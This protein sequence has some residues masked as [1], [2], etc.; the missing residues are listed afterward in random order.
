M[1]V[2]ARRDRQ[3]AERLASEIAALGWANRERFYPRLTSL[4]EAVEKALTVGRNT[5]LLALAFA[6][7]ADNPGGG[8]RGNT[9]W[10]IEA[11]HLA[12]VQGAVAGLIHDPALAAEAHAAGVGG[13]FT[14]RF[15]RDGGDRFSRPF[16][17]PAMVRALHDGRLVGRR[18]IFAGNAIDLGPMA[19]LDLG[20]MIVV[21]ASARVQCAD[22]A[23]LEALGIDIGQARCVVVKSRGHFRGGFDEFFDHARI[24]EVDAPGLT[25]PVLARFDWQHLPRPVLPLDP[26]TSW[27]QA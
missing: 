17:A 14:A 26:A 16:A 8:G 25:S 11:F 7:V 4:D 18:G 6:D 2:T 13:R 12:R 24:V 1:V 3:A 15:N 10:I 21:V 9:M 19:A 5:S 23:F 20:G 22:P 27:T